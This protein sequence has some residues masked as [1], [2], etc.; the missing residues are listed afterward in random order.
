MFI[1]GV[2][3]I[4]TPGVRPVDIFGVVCVF[5]NPGPDS[6]ALKKANLL[7]IGQELL[8]L[9]SYTERLH[10]VIPNAKPNMSS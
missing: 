2:E 6:K 4:I 9:I 10:G 1:M 3:N 5:P 7:V 8:P